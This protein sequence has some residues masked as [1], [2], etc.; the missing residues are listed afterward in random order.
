M[1]ASTAMASSTS[2]NNARAFWERLWRTSGINSIAWACVVLTAFPRAMLIMSGSFGLWRAG[3]IS[4]RACRWRGRSRRARR[5]RRHHVGEW[6][7]LGAGRRLFAVRLAHHRPGVGHGRDPRPDPKPCDPYC[8][9][10]PPLDCPQQR[11]QAA[12][13]R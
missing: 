11:A 6:R 1:S 7:I 10:M 4:K 3:L 8:M 13:T 5:A 2:V 12:L 9:V